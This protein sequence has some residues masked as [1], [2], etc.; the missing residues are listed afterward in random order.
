M[1]DS[2]KNLKKAKNPQLE[3]D[4]QPKIRMIKEK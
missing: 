3:I 4:N 1:L 2:L